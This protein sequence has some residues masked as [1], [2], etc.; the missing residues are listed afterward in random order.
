MELQEIETARAILRDSEV[1]KLLKETNLERYLKLENLL[2]SVVLSGEFPALF[3]E[4]KRAKREQLLSS[5]FGKASSYFSNTFL[6]ILGQVPEVPQNRL[7]ALIQSALRWEEQK[8]NLPENAVFD[9]FHGVLPAETASE[10][11]ER[12]PKSCFNTVELPTGSHVECAGFSP[13]GAYFV[14][15]TADGFLEVWDPIRG[16]LRSDLPYQTGENDVMKVG[17]AVTCLAFSPDCELLV[18][19]CI[20]GEVAVWR[21]STGK[22]VKAFPKCHEQGVTH[23]SFSPDLQSVLSCGFDNQIRVLGMKSGRVL[24]EFPGHESYVNCALWLEDAKMILSASHDGSIKLWDAQRVDCIGSFLPAE[25]NVLSPPP[26]RA[27]L[28]FKR[29]ESDSLFLVVTQSQTLHLFSLV[30]RAFVKQITCKGVKFSAA[31]VRKDHFFALTE[32]GNILTYRPEES[33]AV[34]S[35]SKVAE[36]EPINF[37]CHPTLSLLISF[38]ISGKV[39]FWK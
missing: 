31:Q 13:N 35:L 14:V 28:P 4:S 17:S 2:S 38:D 34:V 3:S 19:G 37:S 25:A 27:I 15:G 5:K 21:L 20:S 32:D 12:L 16:S 6:A 1:M 36:V 22:L 39:K 10:S 29:T 26:I 11:I 7:L 33:S 30:Q 23:V 18:C 24:K 9:L 8:G